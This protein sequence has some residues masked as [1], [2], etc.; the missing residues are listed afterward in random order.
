MLATEFEIKDLG[1]LRYFFGMDA[2]RSKDGIVISQQ[3]YILDLLK[4]IGNLRCG[5]VETQMDPNPGQDHSEEISLIGKGMYQTIDTCG[6]DDF[7][8]IFPDFVIYE[9]NWCTTSKLIFSCSCIKFQGSALSGLQRTFDSEWAVS[10]I[11]GIESEWCSRVETAIVNLRLKGKHFTG[12]ENSNDISGTGGFEP[13]PIDA[14]PRSLLRIPPPSYSVLFHFLIQRRQLR[15][16]QD[17]LQWQQLPQGMEIPARANLIIECTTWFQGFL[18]EKG[19]AS[20]PQIR[21][22]VE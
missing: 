2:T 7:T 16:E 17:L 12:A 3:K 22:R 9:G 6:K 20:G 13:L 18:N 14:L 11:I 5:L 10:D 21:E 19:F 15:E 4:E 8:V 1:S